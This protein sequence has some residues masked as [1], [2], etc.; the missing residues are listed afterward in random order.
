MVTDIT[1]PGGVVGTPPPVATPLT[2]KAG[3]ILTGESIAL[4]RGRSLELLTVETICTGPP[5]F[6]LVPPPTLLF[7]SP[8]SV[9]MASSSEPLEISLPDS[10]PPVS[11]LLED[12]DDVEEEEELRPSLP[13]P[14]P[15]ASGSGM[16]DGISGGGGGALE[17]EIVVT[18]TLPMLDTTRVE[19]CKEEA[20]GG[21]GGGGAWA[22]VSAGMGLLTAFVVVVVVVLF[23]P[24]VGGGAR[25]MVWE[26]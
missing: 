22:L 12:D 6:L 18:W 5:P 24:V 21:G 7:R 10:A 8:A 20:E 13:C 2:N 9:S 23:L 4:G 14:L 19:E 1:C 17:A 26:E 25:G 15:L 16:R 3:A 11:L